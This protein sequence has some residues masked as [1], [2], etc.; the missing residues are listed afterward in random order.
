[1]R[2]KDVKTGYF[3]K[4]ERQAIREGAEVWLCTARQPVLAASL[5]VLFGTLLMLHACVT[6]RGVAVPGAS[7]LG[8]GAEAQLAN[9]CTHARR[10]LPART[11]SAWRTWAGCL[12]RAAAPAARSARR[13]WARGRPSQSACRTAA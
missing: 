7:N 5:G 9:A 1:M 8:R 10:S 11:A 12:P 2:R 6:L 4:A 3:S 13:P